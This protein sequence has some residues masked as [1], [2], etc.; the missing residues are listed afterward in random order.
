[1]AVMVIVVRLEQLLYRRLQEIRVPSRNGVYAGTKLTSLGVIKSCLG[2][3][4]CSDSKRDVYMTAV[5]VT[6]SVVW[7]SISAVSFFCLT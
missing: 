5:L 3:V 6:P 1:M 2:T 4:L 7:L